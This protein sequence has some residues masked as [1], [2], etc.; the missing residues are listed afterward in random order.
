M[1]KGVITIE[2]NDGKKEDNQL[3]KQ[4]D[5]KIWLIPIGL[6]LVGLIMLVIIPTNLIIRVIALTIAITGGLIVGIFYYVSRKRDR[7]D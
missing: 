7:Y 1:S 2:R 3:N 4:G 6:A 5:T